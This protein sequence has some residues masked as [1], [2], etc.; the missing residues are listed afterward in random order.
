MRLTEAEV[1]P[2]VP[3]ELV[4]VAGEW[5]LRDIDFYDAGAG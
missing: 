1:R 2:T 5:R 4:D 3:E